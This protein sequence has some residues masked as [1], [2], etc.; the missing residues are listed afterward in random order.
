MQRASQKAAPSPRLSS[1]DERPQPG[2]APP[3]DNAPWSAPWDAPWTTPWD[4][5]SETPCDR[6]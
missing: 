3:C 4:Q 5:P 6:P 2:D 1:S